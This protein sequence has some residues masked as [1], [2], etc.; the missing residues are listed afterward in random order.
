MIKAWIK[1]WGCPWNQ[2]EW[3]HV[4]LTST[5]GIWRGGHKARDPWVWVSLMPPH[6]S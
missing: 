2:L 6:R 4:G 3:E 1:V 5:S